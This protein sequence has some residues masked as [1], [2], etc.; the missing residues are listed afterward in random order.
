MT[1]DDL[2]RIADDH[3]LRAIYALAVSV[4]ATLELRA[5]GGPTRQ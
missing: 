3:P 4:E 1:P 2:R 5:I